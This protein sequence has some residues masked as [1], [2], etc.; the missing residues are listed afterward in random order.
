LPYI[1]AFIILNNIIGFIFDDLLLAILIPF[2]ILKLIRRK[3]HKQY[4]KPDKNEE[5][6]DVEYEILD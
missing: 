4:N 1:I 6:I 2:L 3:P 5:Y